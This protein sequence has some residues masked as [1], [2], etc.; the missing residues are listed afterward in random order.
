MLQLA[1]DASPEEPVP[2]KP[3]RWL[4][5]DVALLASGIV[6]DGLDVAAGEETAGPR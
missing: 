6:A 1:P 2:P 3:P 5:A 4:W